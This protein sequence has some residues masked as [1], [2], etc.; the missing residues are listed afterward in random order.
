MDG[1]WNVAGGMDE[2][3]FVGRAGCMDRAGLHQ[4]CRVLGGQLLEGR[5]RGLGEGGDSGEGEVSRKDGS[6]KVNKGAIVSSSICRE[7]MG[8]NDIILVL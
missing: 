2:A 4:C 1:V 8:L 3:K 6:G 7:V 5:G